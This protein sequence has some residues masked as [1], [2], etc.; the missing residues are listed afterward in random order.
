MT[1]S[2]VQS[3]SPEERRVKVAELCGYR[4]V[5]WT[6]GQHRYS[7]WAEPG[8]TTDHEDPGF[9]GTYELPD[10]LHDLNACAQME[11]V[12]NDTQKLSYCIAI[13]EGQPLPGHIFRDS[14]KFLCSTAEQR[15]NAFL[16]TMPEESR[17]ALQTPPK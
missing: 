17:E 7:M 2:A 16:V 14:P 12:M 15:V 6:Q 10:Y 1:L 9:H 5:E 3:L 11:K 4:R 13:W 8:K